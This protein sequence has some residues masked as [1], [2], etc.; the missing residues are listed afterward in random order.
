MT[1]LVRRLTAVD[2][3]SAKIQYDDN[4]F[5]DS[6]IIDN[7]TNHWY[8]ITN[9][10]RYIPPQQL[11]MVVSINP[12]SRHITI[13]PVSPPPGGIANGA[14]GGTIS[15]VFYEGGLSEAGGIDYSLTQ[16]IAD[17]NALLTT[18]NTNV[19]TLNTSINN[20]R[21]GWGSSTA[22]IN[23]V[24]GV[25]ADG[26]EH[27]LIAADATHSIVIVTMT[28]A[29]ST[30]GQYFP[31]GTLTCWLDTDAGSPIY[32]ANITPESPTFPFSIPPGGYASGVNKS[33]KAQVFSSK[34]STNS[35]VEYSYTYYLL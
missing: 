12:A 23:G 26:A 16:N 2:N 32:Y 21:N 27:T 3:G 34:D 4:T 8:Q 14:A 31:R 18:L 35:V 11:G 20:L 13:Q 22:L 1:G 25:P 24:T 9:N 28:V 30:A 17:L 10:Q 33:W 19:T 7:A 15:A 5:V 6:I 29:F